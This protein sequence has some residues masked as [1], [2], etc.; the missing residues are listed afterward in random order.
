MSV[1][2][3]GPIEMVFSVDPITTPGNFVLMRA[4]RYAD[5]RRKVQES[6]TVE[7]KTPEFQALVHN[8][9]VGV[10]YSDLEGNLVMVNDLLEEWLGYPSGFFKGG[11]YRIER[12]VDNPVEAFGSGEYKGEIRLRRQ[13][14]SYA[15]YM[16]TTHI[17]QHDKGI[18][19]LM[20]SLIHI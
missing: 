12:L 2:D 6:K 8:L 3:D 9:P 1:G 19:T 18:P 14:G 16:V 17:E 11:V 13:D 15:N 7:D 4:R 5:N 20:L 10:F